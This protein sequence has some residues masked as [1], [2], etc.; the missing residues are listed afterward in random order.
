MFLALTLGSNKFL[1]ILLQ[2]IRVPTFV[3]MHLSIKKIRESKAVK[4][5]KLLNRRR[6]KFKRITLMMDRKT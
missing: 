1:Q 5:D 6:K 3:H 2:K 4:D